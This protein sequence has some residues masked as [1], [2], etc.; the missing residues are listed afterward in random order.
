MSA[1]LLPSAVCSAWSAVDQGCKMLS[2]LLLTHVFYAKSFKAEADVGRKGEVKN[3]VKS[4][5]TR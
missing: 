4:K 1:G 2:A 3:G 5:E